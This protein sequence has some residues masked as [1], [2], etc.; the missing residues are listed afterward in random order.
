MDCVEDAKKILKKYNQSHTLKLLENIKDEK[1]K[2]K[3][4]KSIIETNF[5]KIISI[6]KNINKDENN[7]NDEITPTSYVDSSLIKEEEKNKLI[8]KGEEILKKGQYAVITMAGGQGTRLGCKG[9]KGTF[10]LDVEPKGKYIFEIFADKIKNAIDK[11]GNNIYWYI[12]TSIENYN[13]TVDFFEKNEYFGLNKKNVFFFKQNTLPLISNEG[14]VLV[15]ENYEIKKASDGNGGVYKALK[16]ADLFN[17]MKQKD[18]KWVYVCGVDN[19]MVKMI[20]P[21]FLGLTIQSGLKCASKSVKKA[22]PEE[23]VGIFCKKNGKPATIEYIDMSDEMIHTKKG[24][25]LLFGEANI[26]SHLFS[27]DELE[28]ISNYDLKYHKAIKNNPYLDENG[29]KIIP[30]KPNAYKF[31]S[32]IFDGFQFTEDMLIMR[33]KR[34]EQFAPVKNKEGK[35]SPET[36]KKIYNDYYK[37]IKK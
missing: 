9:P 18:I 17:E 5:E 7:Q 19:I 31:E 36:A 30:N 27:L 2:I 26:I 35:D 21:L 23:K 10:K 15:D 20:D 33:V 32:F 14:E 13:Q 25:E 6:Y 28:K 22:Y 12:M 24:K 8:K 11:Y 34:E 3:L 37:K 16:N 1:N 4:S 29:N